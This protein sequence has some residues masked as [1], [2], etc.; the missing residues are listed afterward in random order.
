MI[1]PGGRNNLERVADQGL[2][3]R[4]SGLAHFIH[5][6][7]TGGHTLE[8][9]YE[10]QYGEA[11][12]FYSRWGRQY[13]GPSEGPVGIF[14]QSREARTPGRFYYPEH[15]SD[16]ADRFAAATLEE[17]TRTEL[18]YGKNLE[19][20]LGD[21]L[22]TDLDVFT[23]LR[24]PVDRVLS[25]YFF[26]VDFAGKPTGLSLY[27][28]IAAHVQPNIQ[29]RLLSGPHGLSPLPSGPIMLSRAKEHLRSCCAFGLTERFGETV[30]LL[31]QA[32]GWEDVGYERRKVNKTRPRM[33]EVPREV[34]RNLA[35]DNDLDVALYD[36]ATELFQERLE[37]YGPTLE[38]D[39]VLLGRRNLA[40]RSA[41]RAARSHPP[42]RTR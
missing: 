38:D 24:D 31:A 34:L 10:R 25:Q 9:I 21:L 14:L 3:P 1:E 33:R 4:S 11:G 23:V 37:A 32:L 27:E 19:W 5:I 22:G 26:T 17:R 36:F 12:V 18:L 30:L 2:S 20:G 16:F 35:N 40:L 15:L 6:P 13:G 39:M 8:A 42:G 28:H 7:K 29:T 41:A